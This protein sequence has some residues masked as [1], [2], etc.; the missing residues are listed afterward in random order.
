MRITDRPYADYLMKGTKMKNPTTAV[1]AEICSERFKQDEKW[2][3]QS[4]LP[5]KWM[6]I[7]LEEVGE[8][9]KESLEAYSK[10]IAE[11][12]DKRKSLDRWRQE[13]I[14]VAAVAVAAVECYDRNK[15]FV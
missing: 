9:C 5:D 11:V 14:Q 7:L 3:V 15:D 12:Y 10:V 1:L 13:M 2:G 6:V 8:A 4:H